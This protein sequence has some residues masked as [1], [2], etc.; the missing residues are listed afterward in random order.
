M[1]GAFSCRGTSLCQV[2][3]MPCCQTL[4]DTN[5]CCH[6]GNNTN[7]FLG[8]L[9]VAS[10]VC[11]LR[12]AFVSMSWLLHFYSLS[13]VTKV[14]TLNQCSLVIGFPAQA[15]CKFSTDY[16]P[17]HHRATVPH[18][19]TPVSSRPFIQRQLQGV[20]SIFKPLLDLCNGH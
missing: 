5:G 3:L 10:C 2:G 7:L 9:S 12:A 20:M 19:S 14:K 18:S 13:C 6:H 8:N 16:S 17:L 1:A 15:E 11:G 4:I